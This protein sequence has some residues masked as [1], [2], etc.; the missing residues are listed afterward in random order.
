MV[1]EYARKVWSGYPMIVVLFIAQLLCG[2]WFFTQAV[3]VDPWGAVFAGLASVIV[4]ILWFG[5]FM[6][7]PNEAKVLQLFGQYVGTAH[8]AGLR[9]ANPFYAKTK[10]STRVRNF[11]SGKLKVND[12]NGSPI[13][14]AAVVV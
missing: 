5:L 12:S 1:R 9:W 8:E 7:H 3:Q 11:E 13:E 10:V 14:I 4:L 6:V 2:Y